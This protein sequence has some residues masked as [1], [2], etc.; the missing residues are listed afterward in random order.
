MKVP[1]HIEKSIVISARHRE[2]ADK[3]NNIVR[4]WMKENNLYND[5]NID[6]LIDSSELSNNPD[7]FIEH[8]NRDDLEFGNSSEYE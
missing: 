8:L 3:H 5:G 6:P 7:K 4:D 1:K 2:I